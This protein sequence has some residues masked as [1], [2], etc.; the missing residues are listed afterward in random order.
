[1]MKLMRLMLPLT[2]LLALALAGCVGPTPTVA[3]AITPATLPPNTDLPPGYP[4]DSTPSGPDNPYPAAPTATAAVIVNTGAP[5]ETP[6]EVQSTDTS[7]PPTDIA[8]TDT[9]VPAATLA[10]AFIT[11]R[12]AG[13]VFEIVPAQ[14]TIKVGTRVTFLIKS[15]SGSFHQPFNFTPPNTFE[16]PPEL[17]EG[18]SFSFTFTEPGT[19]TIL[20]GYHEAA[21]QASLTIE[22]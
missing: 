14:S 3:P 4:A 7:L 13:G 5:S 2:C 6:A 17:G 20:C 12:D 10:P 15:D 18:T 1:M 8:I 11:Y 22:P 9:P 21:M 16:A 19:I